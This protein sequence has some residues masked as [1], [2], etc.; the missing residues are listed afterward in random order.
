MYGSLAMDDDRRRWMSLARFRSPI[1]VH[2]L[3]AWVTILMGIDFRLFSFVYL[4]NSWRTWS[5]FLS[6]LNCFIWFMMKESERRLEKYI[7]IGMS[8]CE[9]LITNRRKIC[10]TFSRFRRVN[11]R[12]VFRCTIEIE[13][14]VDPRNGRGFRWF[15]LFLSC[16]IDEKNNKR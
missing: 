4:S 2:A 10:M 11:S 12:I 7:L 14:K 15:L 1:W 13:T 9:W 16:S 5:Y 8:D 3:I 6:S